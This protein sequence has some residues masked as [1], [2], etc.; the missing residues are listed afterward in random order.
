MWRV[1]L[2]LYFSRSYPRFTQVKHT[3]SLPQI[4]HL[5]G[6]RRIPPHMRHVLIHAIP[7]ILA[8]PLVVGVEARLPALLQLDQAGRA[9]MAQ[10]E[11]ALARLMFWAATL[12][13]I[14]VFL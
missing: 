10:A 14:L 9:R 12:V 4:D 11:D 3:L 5:H 2:S 8:I 7:R 1:Q 13:F 6:R